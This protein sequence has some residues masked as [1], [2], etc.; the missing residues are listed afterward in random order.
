M[1]EA[2]SR[3][4]NVFTYKRDLK[5]AVLLMEFFRLMLVCDMILAR[6]VFIYVTQSSTKLFVTPCCYSLA[7]LS[8]VRLTWAMLR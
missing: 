2:H 1:I 5:T 4:L 3:L 7:S 6:S 8:L